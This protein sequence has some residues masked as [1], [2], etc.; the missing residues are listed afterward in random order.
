MFLTTKDGVRCDSCKI[1]LKT[2]F[3]YYSLDFRQLNVSDDI[4]PSLEYESEPQFSL[5][6]CGECYSTLAAGVRRWYK[7]VPHNRKWPNGIVC[8]SCGVATRGNYQVYHCVIDRVKVDIKSSQP[9]TT[10]SQIVEP[11][12]CQECAKAMRTRAALG[13]SEWQSSPQQ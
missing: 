12:I 1:E 8:E 11:W 13:A 3:V 10:T 2:S 4:I 7:P 9:T 5:D 6:L